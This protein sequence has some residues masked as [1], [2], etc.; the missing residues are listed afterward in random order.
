ML[1]E[2][3]QQVTPDHDGRRGGPSPGVGVPPPAAHWFNK[4][5]PQA[6]ARM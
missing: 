1:T 2:V 6:F 3:R 4:V 5:F